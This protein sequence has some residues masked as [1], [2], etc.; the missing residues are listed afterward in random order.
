MRA[1]NVVLAVTASFLCCLQAVE[2]ETV[3]TGT[4]SVFASPIYLR[5]SYEARSAIGAQINYQATGSGVGQKQVV[6]GTVDFG[7]SDVPME[8]SKL[9]ASNL[10]QFPTVVGGLDVIVNLP[11]VGPNALRLTGPVLAN[12][13]MGKITRWNDPQIRTLNPDIALPDSDIIAIHHATASGT[14]FAL[15]RYL[16]KVSDDWKSQMG[17]GMMVAWPGGIG[18]HGSEGSAGAVQQTPGS[19]GYAESSFASKNHLTPVMLLNKAGKYV[20]PNGD[21][22]AAAE[23]NADWT[24]QQNFAVDLTDMPGEQ[25]WPLVTATFVLV[26]KNPERAA[27]YANALKFFGWAFANGDESAKSL[28]YVPLPETVKQRIM[29]S[30]TK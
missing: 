9:E 10:L 6:L 20:A 15:S 21:T 25:S 8:A 22:F 26:P 18:A 3:I 1:T 17:V 19:I 2:A 23:A 12:I 24:L 13:Y 14:T 30:W 28:D 11:N 7:A 5:W 16:S 4:G 27:A 29:S